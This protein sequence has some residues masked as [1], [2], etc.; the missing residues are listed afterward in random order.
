MSARESIIPVFVP[1]LGCPNN[2]VFCNQRRISG[3]QK[4]ADAQT[5]KDSIELAAALPLNGVKRQLAFYGGSFTA[6]PIEQQTA[7]LDAA[8]EY[9]DRG[10]LHS[11]RLSTRPDAIDEDV[12][13]RLKY[14]G[15]ETIELGAQSLC[16][17][18]L[19]LTNRGH[20][21]K[22]V[23]DASKLIKQFGFKL[24]LQMMTGLPGD[25]MERS[26]ETAKKII[27]L[28]PDGVRIYPTVIVKDT[29]L[30]DMWQAGDYAEHSVEDAV[31]VCAKL[32]PLFK[33]ANIPVIRLGLNPTEELSGGAAAGGAYHPALGEMVKSEIM[34]QK[35]SELLADVEDGS[36]V[37]LTV[38]PS[39]ISQMVGQ[40]RSNI[41][42][43]CS[44]CSLKDV[45]VKGE[46]ANYDEIQVICVEK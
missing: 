17:E 1:H 7:L 5:V 28:K 39:Q 16:D 30:F 15:V 40:R 8:K 6:I 24:I 37:T 12:L 9:M 26:I 36:T 33:D 42:K 14:Y 18:V 45:K 38:H 10:V 22:A 29:E 44:R 46:A 23:E 34:L 35:A 27:A 3:S 41:S 20:S 4:P 2:C 19:R 43:L 32:L 21:A 13:N 31:K 11:I 25:S